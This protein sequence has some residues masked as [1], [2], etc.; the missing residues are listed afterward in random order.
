MGAGKVSSCWHCCQS[1][2]CYRQATEESSHSS[3]SG[4][5]ELCQPCPL[6]PMTT[7]LLRG[8]GANLASLPQFPDLCSERIH[9]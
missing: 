5:W 6:A 4:G 2:L 1:P 3:S 8:I 7:A 9:T